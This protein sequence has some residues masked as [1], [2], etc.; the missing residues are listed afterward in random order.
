MNRAGC[1]HTELCLQVNDAPQD[2]V[3]NDV[4]D[5]HY[6]RGNVVPFYNYSI[7]KRRMGG[8]RTKKRE[9]GKTLN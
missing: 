4:V 2:T 8:I 5:T 1:L 6:L 9:W 3:C 7:G